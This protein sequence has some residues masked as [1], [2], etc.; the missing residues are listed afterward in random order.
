MMTKKDIIDIFEIDPKLL[1]DCEII[2]SSYQMENYDGEIYILLAKDGK[3]FDVEAS[4]SSTEGL[5]GQWEPIET[6]MKM[7]KERFSNK[8][9]CKIFE[10]DHGKE[11]LK[12]IKTLVDLTW[13]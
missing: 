3:L 2:F 9:A 11:A 5:V 4:H 8:D 10:E 13:N 6:T 7:L 1:K 12:E